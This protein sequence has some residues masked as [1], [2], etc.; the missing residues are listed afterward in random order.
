MPQGGEQVGKQPETG[1]LRSQGA[2]GSVVI[3]S[4]GRH[5]AWAGGLLG[6][7]GSLLGGS[8]CLHS[9]PYPTVSNST[10]PTTSVLPPE[11]ST[12]GKGRLDN[13]KQRGKFLPI[14]NF[15]Q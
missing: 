11:K 7:E 8:F 6:L 13:R 3:S 2:R 15:Q 12:V 10:M 9:F 1:G 14:I 5:E 4:E